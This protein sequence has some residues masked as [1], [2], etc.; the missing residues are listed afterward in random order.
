MRTVVG[1]GALCGHGTVSATVSEGR[2]WDCHLAHL[3]ETGQRRR[4]DRLEEIKRERDAGL[5]DLDAMQGPMADLL[6]TEFSRGYDDE[7]SVP[8]PS[9]RP[10]HSVRPSL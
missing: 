6:M 7:S 10:R 4:A 3:R 5:F 1:V 9:T 8:P 2:C